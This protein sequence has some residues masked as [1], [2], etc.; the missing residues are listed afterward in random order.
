[1]TICQLFYC[2]RS[3]LF[4]TKRERRK[5]KIGKYY[6]QNVFGPDCSQSCGVSMALL[7]DSYYQRVNNIRAS[8]FCVPTILLR[9]LHSRWACLVVSPADLVGAAG[10]DGD[11][12]M[13]AVVTEPTAR[14]LGSVT[15]CFAAGRTC[16]QLLLPSHSR[17]ELRHLPLVGIGVVN[18][19]HNTQEHSR[20]GVLT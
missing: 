14:L 1:M 19:S 16:S 10:A 15:Y 8:I 4:T 12:K 5:F 17:H 6:R 18:R 2:N 7:T 20:R 13:L 3:I 9:M 11:G